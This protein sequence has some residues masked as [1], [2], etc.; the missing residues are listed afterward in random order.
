MITTAVAI[1]L[2]LF[3]AVLGSAASWALSRML[4]EAITPSDSVR[5]VDPRLR[6][7]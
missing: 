1:V 2:I 5:G 6:R 3:V 4:V 7:P